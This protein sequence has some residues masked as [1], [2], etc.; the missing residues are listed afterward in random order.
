MLPRADRT[1]LR[2]RSLSGLGR[3]TVVGQH[4]RRHPSG[5]LAEKITM[6]DAQHNRKRSLS[7]G[8]CAKR[9]KPA[10]KA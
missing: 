9:V 5:R 10:Q 1:H 8:E 3:Q 4:F 7:A 6:W 2:H